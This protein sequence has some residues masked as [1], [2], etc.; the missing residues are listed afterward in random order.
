MPRNDPQSTRP[1]KGVIEAAKLLHQGL[2]LALV[3]NSEKAAGKVAELFG[4]SLGRAPLNF[5]AGPAFGIMWL[6]CREFRN[7]LLSEQTQAGRSDHRSE[8]T[9]KRLTDL[10]DRTISTLEQG[11]DTTGVRA[12]WE[13]VGEWDASQA[14]TAKTGKKRNGKQLRANRLMDKF[15]TNQMPTIEELKPRWKDG[16]PGAIG[17]GKRRYSPTKLSKELGVS[18]SAIMRTPSYQEH[19]P[20]YLFN[21]PRKKKPKHNIPV[22]PLGTEEMSQ[23]EA[24]AMLERLADT[25]KCKPGDGR[26]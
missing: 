21:R 13:D 2:L 20:Q 9:I 23:P 14:D 17:E 25:G 22:A 19:I 12:E 7:G 1:D 15:I 18:K 6:A 8:F 11:L 16:D 24:E 4:V 26:S 3:D 10:V 5:P